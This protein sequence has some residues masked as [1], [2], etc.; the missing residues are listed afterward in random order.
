MLH[1]D[2]RRTRDN[3]CDVP[4]AINRLPVKHTSDLI[5]ITVN[6]SV[7]EPIHR[8]AKPVME[9][10]SVRLH[11]SLHFVADTSL[12]LATDRMRRQVEA[13]CDISCATTDWS[14]TACAPLIDARIHASRAIRQSG[15]LLASLQLRRF[16]SITTKRHRP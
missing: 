14:M 16:G 6:C 2:N 11:E 7:T 9:L 3:Q 15:A 8:C 5:A 12:L 1:G 13:I 4:T 10:V